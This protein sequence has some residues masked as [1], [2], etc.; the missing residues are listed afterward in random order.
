MEA[1]NRL[2]TAYGKVDENPFDE[3]K[4]CAASESAIGE[5]ISTR[6]TH[7][8]SRDLTLTG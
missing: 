5:P 2:S 6:V 7:S 3:H 8:P 4:A 1:K